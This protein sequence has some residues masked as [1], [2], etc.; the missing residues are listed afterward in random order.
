MNSADLRAR[1]LDL[2][3]AAKRAHVNGSFSEA[4]FLAEAA[5]NMLCAAADLESAQ[6]AAFTAQG[7]K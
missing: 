6:D 1:A 2:Q 3:E 5:I 7:G 4:Y